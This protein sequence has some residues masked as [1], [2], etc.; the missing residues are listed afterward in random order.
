MDI[1]YS[2]NNSLLNLGAVAFLFIMYIAKLAIFL[3]IG[4]LRECGIN[5]LRKIKNKLKRQIFFTELLIIMIDPYIEFLIA[6]LLSLMST[7]KPMN[8]EI[9]SDYVGYVSFVLSFVILPLTLLV[10]LVTLA[11]KNRK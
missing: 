3:V 11:N 7:N 4:T 9:V 8:G 6:S 5:R 10:I 1:G 2:T